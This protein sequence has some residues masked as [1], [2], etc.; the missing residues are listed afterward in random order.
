MNSRSWLIVPAIAGL[1]GAACQS[2]RTQPSQQPQVIAVPQEETARP[3]GAAGP[4][5][6]DSTPAMQAP[7]AE[8]ASGPT[9]PS[10]NSCNVEGPYIALT[11]DDGPH[12][13]LTPKLL[14]ILKE[15]GVKATFF[16]LGENVA[17][18]PEVVQ[19]AAAEGHEIGNHSWNHQAFTKSKGAGL[20]MQ[21]EQT[22]AAI[23]SATG[24]KP[25]LVRPPYGSTNAAITKRLN[26]EYGLKVVMWDV[27]P[28]D[29]KNRNSDHVTSEILKNTKAGSIVLSHDIHPTT[30]AAMPAT[31]D[32]LLAK[33]FQF[34]TVSELIALDRPQPAAKPPAKPQ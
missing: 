25:V 3:P 14:D 1:L 23:E 8:S 2:A 9:R 31:I 5:V 13:T 15:K 6:G 26:G 22:N 33:G 30:V 17:A 19:R 18:N 32:G 20:S 24:R 12:V 27:D 34:V 10:Y 11:F 16:V 4:A 28:L 29:W 21:V 7:S